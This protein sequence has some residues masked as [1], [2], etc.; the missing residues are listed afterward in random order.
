[1]S[2]TSYRTAPPRVNFVSF[3]LGPVA[4]YQIAPGFALCRADGATPRQSS[5]Q[6][7]WDRGSED[8][9]SRKIVLTM[10]IGLKEFKKDTIFDICRPF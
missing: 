9:Q 10:Q 8:A 4:L 1:M 5:F 3:W 7:F 6:V 2:L